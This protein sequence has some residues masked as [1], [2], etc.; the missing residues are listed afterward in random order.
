MNN[1]RSGHGVAVVDDKL[2]AVGERDGSG[3]RLNSIECI[4]PST[5]QWIAIAAAMDIARSFV[6]VVALECPQ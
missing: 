6:A 5:G 2:Y 4:D 3:T 1:D